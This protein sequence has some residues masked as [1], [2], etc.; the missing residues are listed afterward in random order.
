MSPRIVTFTVNPA[1]DVAME[2]GEARPGHK[3]R[4]PRGD[5]L[6]R[7]WRLGTSTNDSPLDS[8]RRLRHD[9]VGQAIDPAPR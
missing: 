8:P 5:V 7:W 9:V 6:S 4:D 2:A 1:L 3:I